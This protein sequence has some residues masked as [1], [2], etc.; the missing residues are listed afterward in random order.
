MSHRWSSLI[1]SL[2]IAS[3][4][5]VACGKK[6]SSDNPLP[7]SYYPSIIINSDN[8]VV[9]AIDPATGKK[10]WQY[11][12][13]NDSGTVGAPYKPSPIVYNNRVYLTATNSDT[14]YKLNAETGKL[15]AKLTV[16]GHTVVQYPAHYF[17]IVATPIA[18]ANL[19]Y[20]A[21]TNDTLYAIDTG[22]GATKWRFGAADQ[23]P[24]YASPV[25]YNGNIYAATI[26]SGAPGTSNGHV[27]C[28]NKTTGPDANG[29]PIW[30]YPGL[31]V[32]SNASFI[33]SPSISA[34]YIY[35]GSNSDSNMY[36]MYLNPP[37]IGPP[38][39]PVVGVAR[40]MYKTG[41]NIVSSPTTYAGICIFGCNDFYVYCLDTT[42][43]SVV[44]GKYRWKYHTNSAVKSSPIISNQVVYIGGYDYNLYALNIIDGTKHWG[45]PFST[46]GLIKS[47][48]LPYNGSVYV[49]S[50]DNYIYSV[51]TAFGTLKWSYYV[52][53]NIECSPCIDD[54]SGRNQFNSGISGYNTSGNTN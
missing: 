8:N 30:D 15:I 17:T 11:S 23:S 41:G 22:T 34:P 38:P 32:L 6:F 10:N 31:G 1:L 51:D 39:V 9:Y 12:L 50:Y 40:W 13:P 19:L 48:P 43:T 26:G 27:Y 28:I 53:G 18:D 2:S 42:L 49:A 33:S 44:A 24:F 46:K 29:N 36:C 7:T 35:A 21:T 4:L 5:L 37:V 45:K 14:V 20:L 47:S 25:I 52:G 16:S 3:L 54:L